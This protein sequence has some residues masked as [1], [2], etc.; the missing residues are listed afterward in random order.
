ALGDL[1]CC[2]DQVQRGFALAQSIF[3]IFAR[4]TTNGSPHGL[5]LSGAAA[6]HKCEL[7]AIEA[8]K[9]IIASI[10]FLLVLTVRCVDLG[11]KSLGHAFVP[12]SRMEIGLADDREGRA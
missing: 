4:L 5:P 10:V 8:S 7:A 1:G 3:W 6:T 9:G 11:R 2:R 12:E